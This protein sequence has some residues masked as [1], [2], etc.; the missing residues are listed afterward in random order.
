[1][2]GKFG[3]YLASPAGGC[4]SFL[5]E[6]YVNPFDS[7][8]VAYSSTHLVFDDPLPSGIL[9]QLCD[10][11]AYL[12]GA[13]IHPFALKSGI[14]F[15]LEPTIPCVHGSDLV[16]PCIKR[17]LGGRSMD[18]ASPRVPGLRKHTVLCE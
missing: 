5:P 1:M 13:F 16:L 8:P 14:C 15:G 6:L 10:R 9:P 4:V 2:D 7:R 11:Y 18:P 12:C 17:V 3:V